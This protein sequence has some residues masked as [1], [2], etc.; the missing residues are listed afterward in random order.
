MGFAHEEVMMLGGDHSSM[1]K[2]SRGDPR[3]ETV[4]MFIRSAAK[5]PPAFRGKGGL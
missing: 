4:C 3:F 1:C 5:S 2:F